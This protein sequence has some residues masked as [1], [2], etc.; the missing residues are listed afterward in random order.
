M[1]HLNCKLFLTEGSLCDA[2][3]CGFFDGNYIR[4]ILV[5][6]S[7]NLW[8]TPNEL[9]E[10]TAICL[11]VQLFRQ[12]TGAICDLSVHFFSYYSLYLYFFSL[13]LSSLVLGSIGIS[14]TLLILCPWLPFYFAF[15]IIH[16][17]S[18]SC[19]IFFI[20]SSDLL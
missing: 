20:A 2:Y 8:L 1:L 17:S 15:G 18:F 10:P 6:R 14:F 3:I 12:V 11:H 16:V 5:K 13:V 9:C 4:I 19:L 7:E